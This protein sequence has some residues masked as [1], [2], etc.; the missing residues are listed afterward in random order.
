[1]HRARRDEAGVSLIEMVVVVLVLGIVSMAMFEFLDTTTNVT[2]R[3]TSSVVKEN[4]G[5]LALREITEDVRAANAVSATYSA[6]SAC[7]A[8]GSYPANYGTCLTFEIKRSVNASLACPKSVITYGLV[9]TE[10]KQTR[11]DY[12]SNCTT[13]TR[14]IVGRT[15]IAGVANGATPL[16]QFYGDN[17]AL[18]TAGTTAPYIAASSVRVNLTLSYKTRSPNLN[19]SSMV[20]LRNNR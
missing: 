15:M 6:N 11:L 3:A 4:E 13:V 16:F 19:L 8:V 20:A 2:A 14:S 17:G 7:P 10:L 12:A 9:G 18:I 1:M 5:R